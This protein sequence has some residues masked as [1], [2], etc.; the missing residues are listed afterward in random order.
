MRTFILTIIVLFFS[1]TAYAEEF[2]PWAHPIDPPTISDYQPPKIGSPVGSLG[3]IIHFNSLSDPDE[4]DPQEFWTVP[5]PYGEFT[6]RVTNTP[7]NECDEL[8]CPD[9]V[10]LWK[11]P[12]GYTV[13]P[14]S[15]D[16]PEHGATVMDIFELTSA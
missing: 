11:A 5:T 3:M 12:E 9:R 8:L 10:E 16:T 13:Y 2:K 1:M 6:F 15:N 4:T 14:F 7:N